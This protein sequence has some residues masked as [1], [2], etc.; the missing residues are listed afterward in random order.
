MRQNRQ[1]GALITPAYAHA[2][3]ITCRGRLKI[4]FLITENQLQG[5]VE[6]GYRTDSTQLQTTIVWAGRTDDLSRKV[7]TEAL[8]IAARKGCPIHIHV[9]AAAALQ[10]FRHTSQTLAPHA[11][12]RRCRRRAT[13]TTR[14]SPSDALPPESSA[15]AAS[16]HDRL[17]MAIDELSRR[18]HLQP[19]LVVTEGVE[20]EQFMAEALLTLQGLSDSI[21]RHLEQALQAL[22]PHITREA[23]RAFN[24]ETRQEL[25]ELAACCTADEVY[26]ETLTVT[27]SA[28]KSESLVVEVS[29]DVMKSAVSKVARTRH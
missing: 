20:A 12:G 29:L 11:G 5:T 19:P 23:V 26:A 17:L 2:P 16:L 25:D 10:L 8:A 1:V 4:G 13:Y 27:E 14:E 3:C 18:I 9:F 24:L 21:G 22:E 6:F 15:N 7:L 28:D